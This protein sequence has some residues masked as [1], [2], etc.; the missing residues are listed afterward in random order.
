[1]TFSII[2]QTEEKMWK[3]SWTWSI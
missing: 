2:T 1:M 3:T